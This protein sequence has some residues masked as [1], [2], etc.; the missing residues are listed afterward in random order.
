MIWQSGSRSWAGVLNMETQKVTPL[1][2]FLEGD[3]VSSPRWSPNSRYFA[4]EDRGGSG[5][6]YIEIM[7]VRKQGSILTI[8]GQT[9]GNGFSVSL[10]N[11]QW[12]SNSQGLMFVAGKPGR[13]KETWRINID[14][15]DLRKL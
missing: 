15:S 13:S 11:P 5:I 4:V 7:D 10:S 12:M 9:L 8:N 2:T 3:I 14:G 1:A 6:S